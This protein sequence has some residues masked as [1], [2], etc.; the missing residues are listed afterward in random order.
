MWILTQDRLDVLN[1]IHV[2]VNNNE[3]R[4]VRNSNDSFEMTLGTYETPERAKEILSNIFTRK[5]KYKGFSYGMP[6]K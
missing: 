3:V 5:S 2:Y 4:G 6:T 1:C